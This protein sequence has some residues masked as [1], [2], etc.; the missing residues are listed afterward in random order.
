MTDKIKIFFGYKHTQD[1]WGGAN[2]FI[3]A[4]FGLSGDDNFIVHH[5]IN[6]KSDILFFS[7]L[8]CGPGNV[9]IGMKKNY[10]FSDIKRLKEKSSAK[11]V[12]RAVNLNV[13]SSRL[14]L[15]SFASYVKDGLLADI[16]AIRLVNLADFVIF[17]SEFQKSFFKKWGY[18]GKNNTVIHNG[19]SAV[20]N[21]NNFSIGQAHD[22]LRLVS[23]SNFKAFKRH[24][25]VA[26]MSL[27]PGVSVIHMGKWSD[28]IKKHRVDTRGTLTHG[29][30]AD[31][32]KNSDYLLHPAVNDP[33]PNS[34]IE[35]LRFGLP[36]VYSSQKGSSEEIVR[37]NGIPIDENNLEKTIRSAE[38]IFLSLKKK[39]SNDRGYYS[40]ERAVSMYAETFSKYKK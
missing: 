36:V 9:E 17:Q 39:L 13:N 16:N 20:F 33:C 8:S 18:I 23:N 24:E 19:A 4:L 37:G 22:P 40:I 12:V 2:N 14:S 6:S 38:E 31:I 27:I 28:K 3:R 25:I 15:S 21:N 10:H 7:Q 1:P 34:V 11:L 5:D 29:E 26:R 30:I 32:Y 35:A